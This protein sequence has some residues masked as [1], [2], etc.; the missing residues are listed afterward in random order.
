MLSTRNEAGKEAPKPP[1]PRAQ[2]QLA[3]FVR[4]ALAP[5]ALAI[6]PLFLVATAL[7]N[8]ARTALGRDQGIFQY[9]AWAIEKGAVDYRDIRDVNGPL[10]HLVHMA[11]LALGG[12][13][14]HRLRV[15]DLVV[16]SAT[17]AF[18]GAC[19][20]GLRSRGSP[21]FLER[22]AWA[23]AACVVLN[24]QYLGYLFWDLAQ[25]E[26]FFDWFMLPSVGLQLVAQAP[27]KA[28]NA[29]R[30]EAQLLVAVGALSVTPWFGKPT[31]LLFTIGQIGALLSDRHQP[32]AR[33]RALLAFM[34]GGLLA[35][36]AELFFLARHGDVASYFRIQF[37]DVP[38]MYRFIWPRS[39]TDLL[40]LSRIRTPAT[41]A[42]LGAVA[43][44]SLMAARE[45]PARVLVV[46]LVPMCALGSV[47]LQ[48]KGFP[49]HLHPLT[50]G[51]HLQALALAAWVT[52]RAREAPRRLAFA[53]LAPVGVSLALGVSVAKAMQQSPHVRGGFLPWTWPDE[54]AGSRAYYERFTTFDFFPYEMRETASYLREHTAPGDRVQTYGMDPYVLFLAERLSA[55]PYI[56]AYDLDAD[57]ALGG[58]SGGIPDETQAA[59]IAGIQRAHEADLRARIEARPPA[60]FVFFDGAPTLSQNDAWADFD[61]HCAD[62]AA[63]VRAHYRETARFGHDRVWLRLDLASSPARDDAPGRPPI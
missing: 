10:T 14:E 63:W 57:A 44:S 38:T 28:A 17:F 3:R 22:A 40:S 8:A 4:D 59:A 34:T 23:L 33:G 18:V 50:A 16:T 31:Y 42:M 62:A 51:V 61:A 12:A 21:T 25:R 46:A 30:R 26:S 19:L 27:D 20:P 2:R 39:V 47:L 6:P 48:R 35:A 41:L 1:T 56:Y 9:I 36:A 7:A 11:F 53:R 55:T 54:E 29:P 52:E 32:L 24:G 37:V 45:M 15:L 13:D 49:Y 5:L 60:A 58:G 43:I